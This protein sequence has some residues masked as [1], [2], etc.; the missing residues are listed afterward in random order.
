MKI[1]KIARL[2]IF[3]VSTVNALAGLVCGIL[4][5]VAPD[6]RLM[7]AGEL[8]PVI[9]ALPLAHIF[10]QDLRWIGIAML[11]VLWIPN[12]LSTIALWLKH[13]LQYT[14]VVIA[15][16]AMMLWCTFQFI[17]MFNWLA[18]AYF[19]LGMLMIVAAVY[20]S[21]RTDTDLS[22]NNQFIP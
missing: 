9:A 22:E 4:L 2:F 19:V 13:K 3:I 18:V 14:V 12:E 11:I 8:L 16:A 1:N 17:F 15:N 20:L 6:G 7:A 10:F 21:R 5:I